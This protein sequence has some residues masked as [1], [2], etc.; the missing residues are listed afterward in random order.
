MNWDTLNFRNNKL[1]L[2]VS[3]SRYSKVSG[4]YGKLFRLQ[5]YRKITAHLGTSKYQ[6][7]TVSFS[8]FKRTENDKSQLTD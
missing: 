4:L 6:V 2:T 1:A 3:S 5:T 7:Y 8:D